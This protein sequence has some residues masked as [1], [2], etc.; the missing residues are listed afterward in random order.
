MAC[1]SNRGF[2]KICSSLLAQKVTGNQQLSYNDIIHDP[3]SADAFILNLS[4]SYLIGN[5]F[6][7]TSNNNNMQGPG[8][9]GNSAVFV[10][11][12]NSVPRSGCSFISSLF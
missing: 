8:E 9:T 5:G 4:L 1:P 2:R 6:S 10:M 7:A 11:S 3:E 12:V